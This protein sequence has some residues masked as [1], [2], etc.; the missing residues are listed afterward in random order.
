MSSPYTFN[1][2]VQ[3]ERNAAEQ[4]D[5][6]QWRAAEDRTKFFER[7][8]LLSAGAVVFDS[9]DR[10]GLKAYHL[11]KHKDSVNRFYEAL[12]RRDYQTEV[13]AGYGK[14]LERNSGKLF[15]FLDH[16]GVPWNNRDLQMRRIEFS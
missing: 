9:V 16:D 1:Y 8:A 14:R 15:T 3:N 12:S 13:A 11:R 10:F 2:F 4:F 6:A 7:V 5:K